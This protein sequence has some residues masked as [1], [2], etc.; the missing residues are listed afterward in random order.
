MKRFQ[1][2]GICTLLLESFFILNVNYSSVLCSNENICFEFIQHTVLEMSIILTKF[3]I[4][5]WLGIGGL[6]LKDFTVP[7]QVLSRMRSN[8]IKRRGNEGYAIPTRRASVVARNIDWLHKGR[9]QP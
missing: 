8:A 5:A 7:S 2:V 4:S 6:K 9:E 3:F 1:T